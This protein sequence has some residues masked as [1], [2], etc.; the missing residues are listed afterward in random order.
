[1]GYL[2][3]G[4]AFAQEPDWARIHRSLPGYCVRGYKQK[5]GRLWLLDAWKKAADDREH[6]PFCTN[7]VQAGDLGA[8]AV[9]AS[10]GPVAA[11]DEICNALREYELVDYQPGWLNVSLSIANAAGTATFAF[12]ADDEVYD[13]AA[14]VDS[15][16]FV[17]LGCRFEPFN[18]EFDQ[19]GFRVTPHISE[20]DGEVPPADLLSK[21]AAVGGTRVTQPVS[22][23]GGF[24]FYQHPADLWPAEWGNCR[25]LLGFGTFDPFENFEDRFTLVYDA[26][27]PDKQEK[28]WWTRWCEAALP[29]NDVGYLVAIASSVFCPIGIFFTCRYLLKSRQRLAMQAGLFGMLGIILVYMLGAVETSL[30]HAGKQAYLDLAYMIYGLVAVVTAIVVY[31]WLKRKPWLAGK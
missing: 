3:T 17:R 10:G 4:Y 16:K 2:T 29:G 15:G 26:D 14:L 27:A 24:R 13:F 1:M 28:S 6:F 9:A 12:T 7:P 30:K 19:D 18:L 20:E 11:F 5:D 25:N 22:T 23:E 31:S 8:E 21:L